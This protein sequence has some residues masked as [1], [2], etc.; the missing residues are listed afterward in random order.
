MDLHPERNSLNKYRIKGVRIV[1]SSLIEEDFGLRFA[2]LFFFL[3]HFFFFILKIIVSLPRQL[4]VRIRSN[5][6]YSYSLLR[7]IYLFI[8]RLLP[9]S[10][11]AFWNTPYPASSARSRIYS[12]NLNLIPFTTKAGGN[13]LLRTRLCAHGSR[14]K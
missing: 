10:V 14:S 12:I 5:Y 2:L 3:F 7:R 8:P 4:G 6:I 1:I 13:K 11:S 9:W